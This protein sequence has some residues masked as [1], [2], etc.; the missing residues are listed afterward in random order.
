M[1]VATDP[2]LAICAQVDHS[3]YDPK[4]SVRSSISRIKTKRLEKCKSRSQK[5]GLPPLWIFSCCS[6]CSVDGIGGFQVDTW[7]ASD[8]I[9]I[10]NVG[11]DWQMYGMEL[12]SRIAKDKPL[13]HKFPFWNVI[14]LHLDWSNFTVSLKQRWSI[15]SP[16]SN[17]ANLVCHLSLLDEQTLI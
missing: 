6:F 1:A 2:L 5:S 10:K 3:R 13:A 8:G 11:I 12:I 15:L 16:H 7:H 9:F 14:G 17:M 4:R